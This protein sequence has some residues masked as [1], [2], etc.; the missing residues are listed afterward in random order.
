[1]E[2]RNV[3]IIGAGHVG[4]HC[5]CALADA[6]V[7]EEIVLVDRLPGKA[8]A[9][10]LDV[11]DSVSFLPH[12]VT[13]RSGGYEECGRAS[14][15]VIAIGEPRLPGQ[16]RL[17]LLGRSVELLKGLV[18]ELK[19]LQ[20]TCPVVTITNPADIVADYVRK[21]LELERW[22][23][24]GTGTLLDTA[25]LIRCISR[26]A[27]VDR[28]SVTAFSMGEHGDSSMVPFS[29]VTVGGVPFDRLGIEKET[30][31]EQTRR[32]GMEIIEGKGSTEFGIGRAL[33]VLAG[34]ILRDEKR[35]LPVSVLLDGEYGQ[36]GV[37]CGVPCRIGKNGIEEI[38]QFDLTS[39]EQQM[40]DASCRVIQTH[41]DM[42]AAL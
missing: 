40:L 8:A 25:R 17:D 28:R 15:V 18:E 29:A 12:A 10:A 1:M 9:Q 4:S 34:C 11:A 42:A 5:A 37:H 35:I 30:I 16:T 31:L 14:L 3:V 33:A 2:T 27:G 36:R 19:P 26:C 21:G 32:A 23:C 22:R 7:C 24:F 13:I 39:E 6:G 20:L 41:I 38:I